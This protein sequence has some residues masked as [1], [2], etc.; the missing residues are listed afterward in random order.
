M[1][2]AFAQG[3]GEKK[4]D[5]EMWS[6]GDMNDF[7]GKQQHNITEWWILIYMFS[8]FFSIP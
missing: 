4:Y 5:A 8:H 6:C 7:L 3:F 2:L 1:N